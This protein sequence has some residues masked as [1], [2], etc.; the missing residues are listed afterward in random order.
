[1]GWTNAQKKARRDK[2]R[3]EGKCTSCWGRDAVKDRRKCKVCADKHAKYKK[4]KQQDK[5]LCPH[6][7]KAKDEFATMAG[8]SYCTNC[9]ERN[10][11]YMIKRRMRK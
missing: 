3:A 1:M 11:L 2:A 8:Y 9:Q 10:R 4:E 6:C 7:Q 5:R